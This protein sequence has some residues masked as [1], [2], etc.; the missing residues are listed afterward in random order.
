MVQQ[1]RDARLVVVGGV[2]ERDL[3]VVFVAVG[4]DPA[5][6]VVGD[7]VAVA[8]GPA[9]A[10]G[11]LA[12]IEALAA[13][14]HAVGGLFEDVAGAGD[15]LD[16]AVNGIVGEAQRGPGVVGVPCAV[17][18]GAFD[19]DPPAHDLDRQV[20][21][22]FVIFGARDGIHGAGGGVGG[23]V[24]R[25]GQQQRQQRRGENAR[26]GSGK[27]VLANHVSVV[28]MD[29]MPIAADSRPAPCRPGR[30]RPGCRRGS[31]RACPRP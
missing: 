14:E 26:P 23:G 2:F 31:W 10:G 17:H 13:G 20:V 27:T 21:V 6:G 30:R 28:L 24:R 8:V 9:E 3:D 29:T 18:V 22:V 12:D 15:L 7:P 11:R 25:R 5:L 19:G 4:L 1:P 16:R